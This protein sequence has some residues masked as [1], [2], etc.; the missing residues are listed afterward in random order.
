MLGLRLSPIQRRRWEIFKSIRRARLSL[1]T[2]LAVIVISLAALYWLMTG[3]ILCGW[4]GRT[5]SPMFVNY[6]GQDFGFRL[7][8]GL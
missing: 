5:F 8:G 1:Y 4:R 3:P 2:V 7:P 6:S